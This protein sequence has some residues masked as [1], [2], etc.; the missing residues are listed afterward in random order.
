[1]TGR[2]VRVELRRTVGLGLA[3]IL[4]V[5]MLGLL[6]FHGPWEQ[7]RTAWTDQW[8]SLASWQRELLSFL[9]PVALGAGALQGLRERRSRML[10]LIS[11]TSR[12]AAGRVSPT[13]LAIGVWLALGYLV[14]LVVGGVQVV[15]NTSYFPLRWIPV[16]LVGILSLI[17][18]GLLGMGL[19]RVAPSRL[20]PP[21]LAVLGL[22]AMVVLTRAS[23]IVGGTES[24]AVPLLGPGVANLFGTVHE[25]YTTVS[26][27][28]SLGQALWFAGLAVGGFVLLSAT[29]P[30]SRVAAAIPVVVGLIAALLVLPSNLPAAYARDA[31][32]SALVC[33]EGTPR[34]CVGR[35]DENRL[36]ALVG[37]ARQ[38]LRELSVL[39]NAPTSVV[40]DTRTDPGFAQQPL[41]KA[42]AVTINFGSTDFNDFR[43]QLSSDQLRLAVLASATAPACL[44]PDLDRST[45][46]QQTNLRAAQAVAVS[47]LLGE[48][49][50]L[51]NYQLLTPQINALQNK[52][53]QTLR[54]LPLGEQRARVAAVRA[55]AVTCHGDLLTI[56]TKGTA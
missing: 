30:L 33:A 26:G 20:T 45:E 46:E 55:A 37:P 21:L 14:V 25:A 13:A 11:T 22:I 18:A 24:I 52:T 17:A 53:W 39:P 3:A 16:A 27:S 1:M 7:P 40:E 38:A 54:A 47:W 56:L 19:G 15:G 12:S 9:W 50:S 31:G 51:R 8:N 49:T 41:P 2:I 32:A 23:P 28:V 35:A 10:E 5:L 48:P 43:V 44:N 4:V 36:T 42:D 6:Y 34:V 29:R